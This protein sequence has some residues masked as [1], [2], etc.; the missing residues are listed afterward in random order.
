MFLRILGWFWVITGILFLLKPNF[1]RRRIQKKSI[2]VVRRY[3]F[4]IILFFAIPLIGAGARY[5][6]LLAKIILVIG[7]VVIIKG[8]FMLKAKAAGKIMD[9]LLKQP[10]IAF[11]VWALCQI[12]IGVLILMIK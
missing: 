6:G 12:G 1:L 10:V 11:R 5:E 2:K 3:L 8:F 9:F 7:I 4:L